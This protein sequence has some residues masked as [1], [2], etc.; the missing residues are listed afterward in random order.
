[1]GLHLAQC[2]LN[3]HSIGSQFEN[4][5]AA[6]GQVR[7][8]HIGLVRRSWQ[9]GGKEF[10]CNFAINGFRNLRPLVWAARVADDGE[11]IVMLLL[12]ATKYLKLSTSCSL[13]SLCGLLVRR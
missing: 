5:T 10:M 7:V 11:V 9:L 4:L 8:F 12:L 1:M 2:P 3:G 13:S 6:L